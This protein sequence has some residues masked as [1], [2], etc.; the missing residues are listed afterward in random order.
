M[1]NGDIL[2]SWKEISAYLECDRRT[3]LRWEE[4]LGL[5][6]HRMEGSEKGGVFAYRDELDKWLAQRTGQ[7][8]PAKN[9]TE[10]IEAG[11]KWARLESRRWSRKRLISF[12]LVVWAAIIAAFI[13]LNRRATPRIPVDFRI[14][15]SELVVLG[16]GDREL[17]RYDTGV[18]N[19]LETNA[20]RRAPRSAG[21]PGTGG[22][23]LPYIGF[24]DIDLD[25]RRETLFTI[26]TQD[27][28]GE[29]V[30]LCLDTRGRR[31]WSFQAGRELKF[32]DQVYSADYRIIGFDL[33]DINGDGKQEIQLYSTH[34][35]DWPC[36]FVVLGSD[37]RLLGEF[38]NSGYFGDFAVADLNGDGRTEIILCGVNN[39]YGE[40]IVAVFDAS[41]VQGASPQ[42]DRKFR[43]ETLKPG[44]E[45]F[46]LRLPRTDADINLHPV[47][48]ANM[49]F[50][51]QARELSFGESLSGL[52]FEFD[53][54]L[55]LRRV[56]NSHQF[57]QLHKA[58][59]EAGR[60]KS[61]L[62]EEYLKALGAKV[63][64]WDGAA[65]VWTSH[66]A[67]ANKW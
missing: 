21:A 38:W 18:N 37:G 47:E 4:N 3:C 31:R 12:H 27:E 46:Y 17:F 8:E 51:N 53:F 13:F 41:D 44:S 10:V 34:K 35:P 50:I 11:R 6:I 22:R 7:P 33:H 60:V 65:N 55:D 25:G 61:V 67:M 58:A 9:G 63:L 48:A 5:P 23:D 30:F 32:G 20:Y 24:R 40:G 66:K 64:Y 62:N 49:V 57:I 2:R 28:V 54:G 45:K 26:Q 56:R 42:W 14:E 19:L 1:K 16:G 52:F 15:G 39:E 59:V 36:Q 43:C 29:E